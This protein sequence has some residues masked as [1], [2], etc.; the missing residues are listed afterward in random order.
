MSCWRQL[1]PLLCDPHAMSPAATTTWSRDGGG[2]GATTPDGAE[3]AEALPWLLAAVTTTRSV[4][5]T[6]AA[7]SRCALPVAPGRSAQP[8]PVAEQRC[9]W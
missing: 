9:H 1:A 8:W 7:V 3:V 6:S 5:P 2:A 4:A